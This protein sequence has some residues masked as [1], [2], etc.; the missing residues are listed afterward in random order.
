M[1]RR[2]FIAALAL[3]VVARAAPA[4]EKRVVQVWRSP[5][6]GCCGAWVKPLQ[7]NGFSTQ[8]HLVDDTSAMRRS[9]GIPERFGSCHTAK[10]GGYAIEGHVPAGDIRRLLAERPN[11]RGLAAPG[12]PAGSPGM[13]VPNSPPY[14]ILLIGN[15]E[16]STVFA[17]H[18]PR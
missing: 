15:D 18:V 14:E 16:R 3:A 1:K 4:Q 11:A 8:V 6:C 5:S 7:E 12:M 2:R 9:L 17:R 10:V 13:D